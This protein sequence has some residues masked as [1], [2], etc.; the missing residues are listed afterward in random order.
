MDLVA[1]NIKSPFLQLTW[2]KSLSQL[3]S[4]ELEC[5]TPIPKG[6]QNKVF[7]DLMTFFCKTEDVKMSE[8]LR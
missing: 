2:R 6:L 7:I 3:S 1:L 5:N 4:S 8:I